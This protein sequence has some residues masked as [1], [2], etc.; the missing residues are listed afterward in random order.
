[1]VLGFFGLAVFMKGR[2]IDD[3]AIYMAYNLYDISTQLTCSSCT[4]SRNYIP[5]VEAFMKG[6][7]IDDFN[8][9]RQHRLVRGGAW[10]HTAYTGSAKLDAN[11]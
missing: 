10:D 1:M 9:A 6:R 7:E 3:Y 2:Q 11:A 8:F 5:T 4:V